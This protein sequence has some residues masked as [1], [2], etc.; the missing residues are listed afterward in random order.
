MFTA[1]RRSLVFFGEPHADFFSQAL[2][3]HHCPC[4]I[5]RNLFRHAYGQI[6]FIQGSYKAMVNDHFTKESWEN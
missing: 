2:F 4:P 6:R 5:T 1:K 3:L